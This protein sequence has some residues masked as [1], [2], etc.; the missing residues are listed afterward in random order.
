MQKKTIKDVDLSGKTVFIR[1][2][3]NVPIKGGVI[4]DDTRIRGA[5]PTIRLATDAGARVVL[6]SHLGRPLKDKKKAE[7]KGTPYDE[8]K[9]TLKPVYEY[10][11]AL[12]ELQHIS[13][14]GSDPPVRTSDDGTALGRAEVKSDRIFFASDSIGDVARGAISSLQPGQVVLLENLRL[15]EGEEANDPEFAKQLAEGIDIYVNDAFGTA[16]RAHASTEGITHHVNTCVA[17]LLME[18]ELE[19]LGKALHDPERPFVAVLGGAKVSDKIPVI[20]S[21]I[22]RKVD[23]LLIGGAMAYTFFKAEGFTV[24]KSLVENDM[25]PTALEVKRKA[26]E[27]GVQL[28]LPTDHYVVDSY[29]PI[30]SRKAIQIEFTNAGLV[31]LD[32]GPDT[33]GLFAHALEGAKTIVWN[34]PMGMFEEKPFDEGTIAVAEAVA[35]ATEKGATSIV[36]G[37]DSVA[38]VNQAGLA[39]KISHISTGGGATL[40]FLAGDELPG[41]AALNDK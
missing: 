21:L 27:A 17:G 24:G 3:F 30:N 36:G 9:Y 31:G 33:A 4:E 11:R 28:I 7:E 29:D 35:E 14:H 10:L 2:D 40:E 5:L 16:H 8:S 12:L 6:A 26:E 39:D 23:K 19:F 25:M 22:E 20:E 15:H 41:V 18:R 32:I 1:V 13:E 34:G 37:G 38:A